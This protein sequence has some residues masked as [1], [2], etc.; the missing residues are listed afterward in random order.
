MPPGGVAVAAAFA[1]GKGQMWRKPSIARRGFTPL[2]G[3]C[4]PVRGE[5][6]FIITVG[7]VEGGQRQKGAARFKV[8]ALANNPDIVCQGADGQAQPASPG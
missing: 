8:Q 4:I 2:T 5:L 6:Q 1:E 7:S 3:S